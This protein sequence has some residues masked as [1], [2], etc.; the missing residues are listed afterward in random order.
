[1]Q[2]FDILATLHSLF[3]LIDIHR[4]FRRNVIQ[5][6]DPRAILESES[7]ILIARRVIFDSR[8]SKLGIRVDESPFEV[9]LHPSVVGI[10]D[11]VDDW[12]SC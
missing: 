9:I 3:Q 4:R 12:A 10:L 2:R 7:N 6:H 11:A 5:I 1:M 8:L